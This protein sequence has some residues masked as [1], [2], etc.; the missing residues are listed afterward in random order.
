[1]SLPPF[2]GHTSILSFPNEIVASIAEAYVL[3]ATRD[4][5]SNF[6]IAGGL[7]P[8]FLLM[9]VCRNWKSVCT[10]HPWLWTRICIDLLPTNPTTATDASIWKRFAVVCQNALTWGGSLPLDLKFDRWHLGDESFRS[11]SE[12]GYDGQVVDSTTFSYKIMQFSI[13][14][15]F[16]WKSFAMKSHDMVEEIRT[17]AGIPWSGLINVA[18]RVPKLET[19]SFDDFWEVHPSYASKHWPGKDYM[20]TF[21]DAPSLNVVTFA[22]GFTPLNLPWAQ[23]TKIDIS[24]IGCFAHQN[25]ADYFDMVMRHTTAPN[26]S[27]GDNLKFAINDGGIVPTPAMIENPHVVKLKLP[28]MILPPLLL[29]NLTNLEF[30][31]SDE[32]DEHVDSVSQIVLLLKDSNCRLLDL[33]INQCSA[34]Y[35]GDIDSFPPLLP[36]LDSLR[37]LTW[38]ASL[39]DND[40]VYYLLEGLHGILGAN[41]P[42]YLPNLITLA[43]KFMQSPYEQACIDYCYLDSAEAAEVWEIVQAR[44]LARPMI[45][46]EKFHIMLEPNGADPMVFEIEAFEESK[47]GRNIRASGVDF[48]FHLPVET[49]DVDI[50]EQWLCL[51]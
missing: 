10:S 36:Y 45:K 4:D 11:F 17:M 39:V 24:T 35:A 49:A 30:Y 41:D 9:T 29:P 6:Q 42:V 31:I 18:N 48:E 15:S 32:R 47:E 21:L 44:M 5:F 37:S 43:I 3:E 12:R 23:L 8:Q 38:N 16:R 34:T 20:D 26:V 51:P 27:W 13:G 2:T 33:T 28:P 14:Q 1:M 46:M 25:L 22:A 40:I 50:V 7:P 19:L